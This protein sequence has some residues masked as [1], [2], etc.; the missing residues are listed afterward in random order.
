VRAAY[1]HGEVDLQA[2]IVCRVDGSRKETTTGR[3]LLSE[4][5]PKKIGFDAGQQ[6]GWNKKAL[7]NLIDLCYRMCGEKETVLL[8]DRVGPRSATTT[9]PR[10]ASP[11]AFKN[12]LIPK[13]EAGVSLEAATHDVQEIENQYLEGLITDGRALQQGHRHLGRRSPRRWPRR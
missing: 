11:S 1:D 12:M 9:H 6:G 13:K 10:R 5:V 2:K 8:A 3:V 4:I 7:G